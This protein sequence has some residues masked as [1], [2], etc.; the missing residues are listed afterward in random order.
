[1]MFSTEYSK[2]SEK[3]INRYE[4]VTLIW[5]TIGQ[6]TRA[7]SPFTST[8]FTLYLGQ[9]LKAEGKMTVL[10]VFLNISGVYNTLFSKK[11]VLYSNKVSIDGSDK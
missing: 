11:I 9:P 8:Y 5:V 6:N 3:T 1:M 7:F 2:C 10:Y 4:P